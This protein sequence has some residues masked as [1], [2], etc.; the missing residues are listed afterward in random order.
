MN[1]KI[2][3]TTCAISLAAMIAAGASH[4]WSVREF[5]AHYQAPRGGA[6]VVPVETPAPPIPKKAP[7]QQSPPALATKPAEPP[8][9]KSQKDFYEGLVNRI[10]QLQNQNTYLT[11]QLAE[12]NRNMMNLEFTVNSHSQQFRP[13]PVNQPDQ[14]KSRQPD[15]ENQKSRTML[16]DLPGVLPPRAFPA[17]DLPTF[18]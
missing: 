4:W 13:L 1:S 8:L 14:E 5:I 11:D 7:A 18:E 2:L 9:G 6:P 10:E 12:T 15:P 3:P 17:E 16:D